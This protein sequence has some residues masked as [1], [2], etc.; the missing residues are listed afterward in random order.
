M[1][2]ED[3]IIAPP[4]S[5]NSLSC[6]PSNAHPALP[7][8]KISRVFCVCNLTV[9]SLL[10]HGRW[11]GNSHNLYQPVGNCNSFHEEVKKNYFPFLLGRPCVKT[12][13]ISESEDTEGGGVNWEYSAQIKNVQCLACAENGKYTAFKMY[14]SILQFEEGKDG[15]TRPRLVS[16]AYVLSVPN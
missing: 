12:G 7:P 13:D 16:A 14:Q 4:S 6:T 10:E 11:V 15:H 3:C 9:Q 1:H 2:D 5:S 8:H